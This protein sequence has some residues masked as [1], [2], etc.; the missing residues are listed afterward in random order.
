MVARALCNDLT[1]LRGDHKSFFIVGLSIDVLFWTPSACCKPLLQHVR[2]HMR[3]LYCPSG[4]SGLRLNRPFSSAE[5]K[6]STN[7]PIKQTMPR[8]NHDNCNRFACMCGCLHG[9]SI[10]NTMRK[11]ARGMDGKICARTR[12]H[13]H[14]RARTLRHT[15]GRGVPLTIGGEGLDAPW[16]KIHRLLIAARRNFTNVSTN[17]QLKMY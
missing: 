13:T 14:T 3:A 5:G 12:T 2:S 15:W 7:S 17:M 8:A 10:A 16:Q 6:P 4:C 1:T 9:N 11:E